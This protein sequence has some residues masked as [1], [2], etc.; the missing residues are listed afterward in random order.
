MIAG[1]GFRKS[2]HLVKTKDFRRAYRDG[3]SFKRDWLTLYRITNNLTANRIGFAVSARAVKL[4]NRRNRL[5]RLLREACRKTKKDLKK[6]YDIVLSVKKE[7][8]RSLKITDTE[9]IFLDLAKRANILDENPRGQPDK[10][11]S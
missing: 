11:L 1:S 4:A 5:K 9:E 8:S 2:E 10:V 7:P 6:G 3:T